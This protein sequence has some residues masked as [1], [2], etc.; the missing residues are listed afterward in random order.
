MATSVGKS[1]DAAR[2]SARATDGR[3]AAP[4]Y[5]NLELD[6]VPRLAERVFEAFAE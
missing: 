5:A 4:S 3:D 2:R 6:R 1:A